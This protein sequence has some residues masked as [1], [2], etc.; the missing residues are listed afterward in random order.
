[1]KKLMLMATMMA[2]LIAAVATPALAAPKVTICHRPLGNPENAQTLTIGA[3]AA[4]AHLAL[5]VS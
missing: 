3:P 2:I 4:A 1:V 5:H